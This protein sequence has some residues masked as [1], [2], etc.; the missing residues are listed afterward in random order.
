MGGTKLTARTVDGA[1]SR[2]HPYFVWDS[3]LKGF[4]LKVFPSG[5]KT[6]VVQFRS[7]S[8]GKSKR[9]TIGRSGSPW[10]PKAAREEAGRILHMVGLG[11]EPAE[12]GGKANALQRSHTFAE[13][14]AEFLELYAQRNWAPRTIA[15]HRSNIDRWLVPVLGQT[16]ITEIQRPQVIRVLDRVEQSKPALPRNLFVL[17]RT[18]FNWG[19]ERGELEASPIFG[20]KPPKPPADRHH[21]LSDEEL[22]AVALVAPRLGTI[23]SNLVYLLIFTGQR[24]REVAEADWSEF[25]RSRRLWTIPP[26]RTKNSREHAMPLNAAAVAS[27]DQLASSDRWPREGFVLSHKPGHPVSGF[28]KMKRRLDSALERAQQRMR[29]WRLHDLRRTVAT[30]MQRLGVRFEVTEAILNHVSITQAGVASVYQ[31]H[32][33]AEEKR[34]ALDR[35]GEKLQASLEEWAESRAYAPRHVAIPSNN[36]QE[37]AKL[38][39]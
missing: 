16:R 12:R 26:H 20:M 23:W 10:S 34:E 11:Q 7:P 28:S 2:D 3:E 36:H 31:R 4:G 24:L 9:R 38:Y 21:I 15:T 13:F 32:D 35:W 6:Y 17:M 29:P 8:E 18:M 22:V 25:D 5:T 30:N 1:P 39:L 19:V 37:G 33:W 27:L 14:A